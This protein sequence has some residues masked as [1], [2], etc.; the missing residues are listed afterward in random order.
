MPDN[1]QIHIAPNK[2]L[3]VSLVDPEGE[4][5]DGLRQGR[6]QTTAG[7]ILVLPRP[8]VVEL[9]LVEPKPGEE[10]VIQKH[11]D[12][13]PGSGIHWTVALSTRSELARAA[14][15]EPQDLTP[16]LQASIEQAEQ[17]KA[18]TASPTPI[19]KPVK[20]ERPAA[21]QPRLFDRGQGTGTYGPV[22]DP[23]PDPPGLV[24]P[25]AARSRIQ[26]PGQIPANVATRE[27]LSFIQSD[28]NTANWSDQS[29][30][31]LASTILIAAYRAGHIGLWERGE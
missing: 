7:E 5:D 15:E 17:R 12:G 21:E 10:I 31:D 8:A 26:K 30:Q 16:I 4:Y 11:W 18:A 25:A 3:F 6:Y 19:R 13:R 22:G 1:R 23:I 28:P 20:Q 24:L 9:N 14:Q 2:P 29:R 27:I